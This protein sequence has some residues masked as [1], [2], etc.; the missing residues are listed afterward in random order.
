MQY[1]ELHVHYAFLS[2]CQVA[3]GILLYTGIIIIEFECY[4]AY[5]F[6]YKFS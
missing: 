5:D 1:L 4:N 3:H 6:M 2:I